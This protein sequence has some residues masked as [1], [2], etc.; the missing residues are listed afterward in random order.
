LLAWGAFHKGSSAADA[1][2]RIIDDADKGAL[3]YDKDGSGEAAQVQ[4]AKIGK[5]LNLS[6]WDFQI[7]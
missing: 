7:F 5:H 1:A 3:N 4:F 6:F 2:D